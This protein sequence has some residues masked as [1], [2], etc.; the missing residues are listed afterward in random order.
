MVHELRPPVLEQEGLVGALRQRLE[1]VEGRAGVKTRLLADDLADL[2]A[3][4]EEELYRIALEALN[5]ALKHAAANSVNIYVRTQG[6]GIELEIADN[7]TGFDPT[8]MSA[9]SGIGLSSMRERAE[10]LGATL[11]IQSTPGEGTQVLVRI[12]E[13]RTD[14]EHPNSGRR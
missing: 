12:A 2:P 1:A 14:G 13:V 3:S 5:N 10:K 6:K 11:T 7:G 9:S 4:V 8:A